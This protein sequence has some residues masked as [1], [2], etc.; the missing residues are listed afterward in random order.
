MSDTNVM[1][2][3]TN[4]DVYKSKQDLYGSCISWIFESYF[5]G[6]IENGENSPRGN[7]QLIFKHRG[8]VYQVAMLLRERSCRRIIG[9]ENCLGASGKA[10]ENVFFANKKSPFSCPLRT[11][12][13]SWAASCFLRCWHV[14]SWVVLNAFTNVF[15][16][17]C[18]WFGMHWEI[19][20]VN[21][22]GYVLLCAI[23]L[24]TLVKIPWICDIFVLNFKIFLELSHTDKVYFPLARTKWKGLIVYKVGQAHSVV[25]WFWWSV[26]LTLMCG[27]HWY[28]LVIG[29]FISYPIYLFSKPRS[30]LLFLFGPVGQI[31]VN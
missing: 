23:C 31:R 25:Y 10:W 5:L 21:C 2:I 16:W 13:N 14:C 17:N 6:N 7:S 15:L 4:C 26:S 28:F 20:R 11:S 30:T 1:F 9:K 22:A 24:K 12:S 27:S 19:G 18:N 29:S 3:R 8:G